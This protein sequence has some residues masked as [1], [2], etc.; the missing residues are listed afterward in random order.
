[1]LSLARYQTTSESEMVSVAAV[2]GTT[3]VDK[4]LDGLGN[5]G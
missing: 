4:N 1:M 5:A 2:P 3:S